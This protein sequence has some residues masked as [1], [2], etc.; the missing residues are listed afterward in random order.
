MWKWHN[1]SWSPPWFQYL[2]SALTCS[3]C[4]LLDQDRMTHRG[5]C[6]SQT[7]DPSVPI[8][9]SQRNPS[10]GQAGSGGQAFRLWHQFPEHIAAWASTEE[11]GHHARCR[12]A[13]LQLL[14]AHR[15]HHK[16]GRIMTDAV[17]C[18]AGLEPISSWFHAPPVYAAAM[19]AML[20]CSCWTVCIS[21]EKM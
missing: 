18:A 2:A 7:D 11:W 20:W 10:G 14:L 13:C 4:Q 5:H 19:W 6:R 17:R 9:R 1:R 3:R 21:W 8:P 16:A 12:C 15:S